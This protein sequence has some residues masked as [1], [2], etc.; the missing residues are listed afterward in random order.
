LGEGAQGE[1]WQGNGLESQGAARISMAKVGMTAQSNW[2]QEWN[3]GKR[4]SWRSTNRK[5][6]LE[7][8]DSASAVARLIFRSSSL[9]GPPTPT[10]LSFDVR[11]WPILS[12]ADARQTAHTS[13]RPRIA[14]AL[15]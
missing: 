9:K 10:G 4:G 1:R 12:P 6:R 7:S 11:A 8:P 13:G 3:N 15:H 5:A 14:T 2:A